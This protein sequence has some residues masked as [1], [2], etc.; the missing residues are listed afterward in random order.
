MGL[1]DPQGSCFH[2]GTALQVGRG[3]RRVRT[4]VEGA[5]EPGGGLGRQTPLGTGAV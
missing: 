3:N 5:C 2:V 1:G 4:S